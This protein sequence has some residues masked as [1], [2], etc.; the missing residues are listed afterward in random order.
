MLRSHE[1]ENKYKCVM[2]VD[3]KSKHSNDKEK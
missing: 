1:D 3:N 2:M